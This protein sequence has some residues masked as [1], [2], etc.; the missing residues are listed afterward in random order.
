MMASK[1]DIKCKYA[2]G[3]EKEAPPK[4]QKMIGDYN[5]DDDN[6]DDSSSSTDDY[7]SNSEEEVSSEKEEMNLLTGCEDELLI[8]RGC[9][10]NVDTS[11]SEKN[12]SIRN[13][14]ETSNNGDT[15]DDEEEQFSDEGSVFD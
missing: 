8:R 1:D 9:Y 5:G 10:G 6:C 12:D 7:S 4:K 13:G 2:D 15:S 14:G 11:D 3:V